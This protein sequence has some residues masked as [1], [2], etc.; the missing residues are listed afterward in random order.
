MDDGTEVRLYDPNR[1][2]PEWT[3][4][5]L[6]DQCA[7]FL[8][9]VSTSEPLSREA[10]PFPNAAEATGVVFG[11]LDAAQRFCQSTVDEQPNVRCEV[12]D[13][14]GRAHPPMLVVIHPGQQRLDDPGAVSHSDSEIRGGSR[15]G[16]SRYQAGLPR[17]PLNT[18]LLPADSSWLATKSSLPRLVQ[19]P[20]TDR[21]SPGFRLKPFC[22]RNGSGAR[23][24]SV[25]S[26]PAFNQISTTDDSDSGLISATVPCSVSIAVPLAGC[27]QQF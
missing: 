18:R 7:V 2:P 6:G 12:F 11:S 15:L 20:L 9:D 5:V 22:L 23:R 26:F 25:V 10:Q 17:S 21:E 1:E 4:L 3:G 8:S 14:Q 16:L 13:G 27:R 24:T 19:Y